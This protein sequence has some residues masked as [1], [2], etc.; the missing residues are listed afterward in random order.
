MGSATDPKT[1]APHLTEAMVRRIIADGPKSGAETLKNLRAAFPDSPLA[2][3]VA[4]L[5]ELAR[6]QGK[7]APQIL[8]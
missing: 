2:L 4:A 3:R 1:T 6:Q 5:T 7:R 8:A